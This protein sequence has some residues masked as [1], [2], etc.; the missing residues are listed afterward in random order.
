MIGRHDDV[1]VATS[2]APR[3][4][5]LLHLASLWKLCI[6][7]VSLDLGADGL[8]VGWGAETR[9]SP[10]QRIRTI[11]CEKSLLLH[12]EATLLEHRA[13]SQGKSRA[14]ESIITTLKMALLPARDTT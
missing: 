6:L 12:T 11:G 2:I 13:S 1:E 14:L 9:H 4:R 5:Q 3:E 7:G 8:G 10:K